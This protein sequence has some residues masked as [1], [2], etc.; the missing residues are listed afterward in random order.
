MSDLLE[1]EL[2]GSTNVWGERNG[3]QPSGDKIKQFEASEKGTNTKLKSQ[4]CTFYP[5]SNWHIYPKHISKCHCKLWLMSCFLKLKWLLRHHSKQLG[6]TTLNVRIE[7]W[8]HMRWRREDSDL[9][10]GFNPPPHHDFLALWKI[11]RLLCIQIPLVPYLLLLYVIKCLQPMVTPMN[12]QSPK[13][14]VSAALLSMCNYGFL[15]GVSQ[16]YI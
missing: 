16:Y 7:L 1:I 14:P 2:V 10:A 13:C 12:E 6:Q 11:G 5:V 8:V 9:K 3:F 4:Q 15:E